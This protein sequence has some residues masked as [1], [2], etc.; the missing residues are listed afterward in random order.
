MRDRGPGFDPDAVPADRRGVRDS[1]VGRME[2][3]GGRATVALAPGAGHRGRAGAMEPMTSV[4]IVDDHSLFRAGVR[5][6]LGRAVDVLGD[7]GDRRGRRSRRSPS[8]S[9]TSCC[10]TC[11]CRAAAAWR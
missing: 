1:I 11:T 3:H 9:P 6:E 8:S 4:V 2:R 7:A 10:S 5:A